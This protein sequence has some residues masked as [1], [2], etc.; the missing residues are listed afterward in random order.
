MLTAQV[1]LLGATMME[2]YVIER[3]V[4]MDICAVHHDWRN[5]FALPELGIVDN[6][7]K[8]IQHVRTVIGEGIINSIA[9]L[10]LGTLP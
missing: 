7:N 5:A 9:A 6:Q 10:S 4:L 8:V 1:T 2:F 3:Q